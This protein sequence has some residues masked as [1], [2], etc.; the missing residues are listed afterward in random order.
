MRALGDLSGFPALRELTLK[1]CEIVLCPSL[2]GAVQH[3]SLTRMSFHYAH[4]APECE[5]MVLQLSQ[6]LGRLG[7]GSVVRFKK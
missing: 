3:A 7:R 5:E 1:H 6:E 4:P 2:L